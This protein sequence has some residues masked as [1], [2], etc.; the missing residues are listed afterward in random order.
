MV[1]FYFVLQIIKKKAYHRAKQKNS[2]N[3]EN[4]K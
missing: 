2:L 1:Y 4:E 3:E